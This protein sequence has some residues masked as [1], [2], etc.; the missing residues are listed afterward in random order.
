MFKTFKAQLKNFLD[1]KL[2]FEI[3][4]EFKP[5]EQEL[6]NKKTLYLKK[7]MMIL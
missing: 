3:L 5:L 1:A 6:L 2:P 4:E 7:L